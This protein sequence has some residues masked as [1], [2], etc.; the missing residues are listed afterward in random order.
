MS[1]S[2]IP[3]VGTKGFKTS[4]DVE[5]YVEAFN[6]DAFETYFQYYNPDISVSLCAISGPVRS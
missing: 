5:E 6:K 3:T 1:V 2:A 4:A